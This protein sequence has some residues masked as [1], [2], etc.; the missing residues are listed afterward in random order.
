L[1]SIAWGNFRPAGVDDGGPE[2]SSLTDV[3]RE[4]ENAF[5]R[6]TKARKGDT[7][8]VQKIA[9]C[10]AASALAIIMSV[11]AAPA[12]MSPAVHY[13]VPKIQHVDCAVGF[14]VGPLG[15]CVIGSDEP[16]D[17]AP[18]PVVE[19]RSV[20]EGCETKSVN[21]TDAEGNSETRTKT[22]CN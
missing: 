16:R 3:C 5:R 17:E 4:Q 7:M 19:H 13:G 9:A 2:Q 18:P 14:H 20:D 15:T 12:A 22:N 6:N 21:R 10:G 11:G 1:T 8:L